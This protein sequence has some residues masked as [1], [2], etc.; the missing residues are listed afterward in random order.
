MFNRRRTTQDVDRAA[1][2]SGIRAYDAIA[3]DRITR[4]EQEP[5]ALIAGVVLLD[6]VL[7][8]EGRGVEAADPAA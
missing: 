7:L 8:E 1:G 4:L 3:H 2:M 5:P 6:D